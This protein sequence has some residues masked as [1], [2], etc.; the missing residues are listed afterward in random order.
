MNLA[1]NRF[2][3]TDFRTAKEGDDLFRLFAPGNT[4]DFADRPFERFSDYRELLYRLMRADPVKYQ[5]MHKGT[6]FGFMSWL[7][8]DLKNYERGLFYLDAAISEDV[9]KADPPETWLNNPGPRVLIL[10]VDPAND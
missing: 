10:D 8:F 6:P 7:A 5:R 4:I 9:R 1:L 2:K 3:E